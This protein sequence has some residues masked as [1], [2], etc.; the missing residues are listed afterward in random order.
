LIEAEVLVQKEIEE[1]SKKMDFSKGPNPGFTDK[2]LGLSSV[3][4]IRRLNELSGPFQKDPIHD[5][6]SFPPPPEPPPLA[7]R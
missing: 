3:A 2:D 1:K 5:G 4:A 6:C 7:T